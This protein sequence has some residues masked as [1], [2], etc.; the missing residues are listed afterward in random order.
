MNVEAQVEGGVTWA[1]S[2]LFGRPVTFA[3]GEPVQADEPAFPVLRIDRMPRIE[4]HVVPSGLP[5]FGVGEQ[6]VP[7]VIPAEACYLGWQ[8]SLALLAQLV[9]ADVPA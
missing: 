1:L 2:T 7:A 4:T 3:D 5:P 8:E 6:P 9:E